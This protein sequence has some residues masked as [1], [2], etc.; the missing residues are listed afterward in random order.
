[1][2][3]QLP[4]TPNY[5]L[6]GACIL[7][8]CDFGIELVHNLETISKIVL[9]RG[10][11]GLV[12]EHVENLSKVHSSTI[13]STIPD[14][15]EHDTVRVVLQLNIIIHPHLTKNIHGLNTETLTNSMSKPITT[16]DIRHTHDLTNMRD[17]MTLLI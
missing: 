17:I 8:T 16:C 2:V 12:V 13:R 7:T 15:P 9:D 3:V 5:S 6:L 14:Q 10:S 1:M 11:T 4:K